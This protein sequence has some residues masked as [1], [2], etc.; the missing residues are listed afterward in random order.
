MP[1]CYSVDRIE[2]KKS[3]EKDLQEILD[4]QYEAYQSEALLLKIKI[5]HH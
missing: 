5:L 2:I 1:R 4:L 3:E